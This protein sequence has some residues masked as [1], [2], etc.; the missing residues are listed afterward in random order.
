MWA[1]KT[2]RNPKK[3]MPQKKSRKKISYFD[4]QDGILHAE[5]VSIL[6][7][8]KRTKTPFYVYSATA[9]EDK[10]N[11]LTRSLKE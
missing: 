8:A 5:E 11:A 3:S 4:F 6:E 2:L 9:L 7:L 10:Y 1:I